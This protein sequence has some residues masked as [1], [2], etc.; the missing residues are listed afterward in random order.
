MKKIIAAAVATAFV[1]PAFAAEVSV[2]GHVEYTITSQ[3]G[4]DDKF[5][6]GETEVNIGA[7]EDLDN[8]VSV[9]ATIN[10]VDD[11]G[12]MDT[13]G[14]NLTFSGGFGSVSVGDVSGAVDATGDYTD[15]APSGG[16]FNGD[17]KNMAAT[18]TLPTVVEGL[19]VM[20]SYSPDSQDNNAGIGHGLVDEATAVSLTYSAGPMAGYYGTE[21]WAPAVGESDKTTTFGLKYS[22]GAVSVAYERQDYDDNGNDETIT[23]FAAQ[24][25][26]GAFDIGFEKQEW[27]DDDNKGA[28]NDLQNE[29]VMFVQ[30]NMGPVDLY[31]SQIDVDEAAVSTST[32]KGSTAD[33]TRVGVEYVF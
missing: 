7:S 31:V 12:E 5:N 8:G 30:Y 1:V 3:D 13:Q 18:Y 23:G 17:G 19:K 26:M 9:S 25:K 33:N 6:T 29:T 16:G 28:N 14:T 21:E 15:M 2:G 10:L 22:A 27:L 32:T 20:A 24:Y 11:T 4:A